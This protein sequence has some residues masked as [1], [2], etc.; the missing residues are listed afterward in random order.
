M[1]KVSLFSIEPPSSSASHFQLDPAPLCIL[2]FINYHS[3]LIGSAC[4]WE[5][6]SSHGY[7]C[8]GSLLPLYPVRPAI[9]G[10]LGH[11]HL[12]NLDVNKVICSVMGGSPHKPEERLPSLC[13]CGIIFLS[14]G[15]S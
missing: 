15:L 7:S 5:V 12:K 6:N 8:G 14:S 3:E 11:C 10:A 1:W 13:E 2:T 9:V 4:P